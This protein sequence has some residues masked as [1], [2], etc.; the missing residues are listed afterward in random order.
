VAEAEI[1]RRDAAANKPV[2]YTDVRRLEALSRGFVVSVCP[3]ARQIEPIPLYTAAAPDVL[4]TEKLSLNNGVVGFDEGYNQCRTDAL[5]LGA[6]PQKLVVVSDDVLREVIRI[7]QRSDFPSPE[8]YSQMRDALSAQSAGLPPE[9]TQDDA[10]ELQEIAAE[11]E[12]L[13]IKGAYGAFAVGANWM[14]EKVREMGAQPQKPVAIPSIKSMLTRDS[15]NED[16][17]TCMAV[18]L[19]ALTQALEAANVPYE[20][21]K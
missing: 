5:A 19:P 14:R 11:A 21:K 4:P 6:Q 7:W 17:A 16:Y 10:P 2:G 8:V 20:V 15:F 12:R 9:I 18:P 1:A 13:G 3:D